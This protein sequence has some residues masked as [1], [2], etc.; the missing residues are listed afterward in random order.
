MR[1]ALDPGRANRMKYRVFVRSS[2]KLN[3]LLSVLNYRL[4]KSPA[5][6]RERPAEWIQGIGSWPYMLPNPEVSRHLLF[7]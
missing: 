2:S 5:A 3:S 6:S 4:L 1:F 7:S